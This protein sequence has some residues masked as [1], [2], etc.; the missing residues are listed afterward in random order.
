MKIRIT[1]RGKYGDGDGDGENVSY[2]Y[3]NKTFTKDI[4]KARTFDTVQEA[5]NHIKHWGTSLV[6]EDYRVN[7]EFDYSI[8][9][10]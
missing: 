4:D 9:G 7:I 10:N 6:G 3:G 1:N 8:S 5:V 2:L